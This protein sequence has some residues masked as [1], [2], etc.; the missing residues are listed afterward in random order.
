MD[1]AAYL[2]QYGLIF[3]FLFGF[4]EQLNIPGF[5]GGVM[6]PVMGAVA[7]SAGLEI[8]EMISLSI[9]AGLLGSSVVYLLGRAR[10]EHVVGFLKRRIPV[11]GDKIDRVTERMQ[12]GYAGLLL[13]TLTPVVR[14]MVALPAGMTRMKYGGY[15]LCVFFGIAMWN[16]ALMGG[17]YL[18]ASAI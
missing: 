1:V 9:L 13:L 17:G 18:L 10:G 14:T 3:I 12:K 2:I 8:V 11:A 16:I 4:L 5:S 6:F 15:L 7:A